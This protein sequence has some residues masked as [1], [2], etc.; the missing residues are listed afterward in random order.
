MA[1]KRE[2]SSWRDPPSRSPVFV[3][4]R[5][6][7]AYRERPERDTHALPFTTGARDVRGASYQRHHHVGAV[8]RDVFSLP[9]LLAIVRGREKETGFRGHYDER[10]NAN[11]AGAK[12]VSRLP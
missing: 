8:L 4:A 9:S 5:I 2:S 11:E 3:N 6:P 12:W 10:R 1:R 7:C